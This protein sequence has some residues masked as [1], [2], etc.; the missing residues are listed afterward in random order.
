VYF[1]FVLNMNEFFKK[2]E[3][4]KVDENPPFL[5]EEPEIV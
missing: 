4:I 3:E 2:Y 5:T 1:P